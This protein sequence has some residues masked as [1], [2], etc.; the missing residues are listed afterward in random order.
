MKTD[1]LNMFKIS[2]SSTEF[3]QKKMIGSRTTA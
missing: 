2:A 1:N 3:N